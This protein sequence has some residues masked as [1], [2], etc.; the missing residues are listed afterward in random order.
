MKLIPSE[1]W[2]KQRK[3]RKYITN[4]FIIH[5]I[6][7]SAVLKDKYWEDALNAISRIPPSGRLLKVVY[8]RIG[9][10]KVK[11]VTAYWLD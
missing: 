3:F 7:N 4:D 2:K 6:Q 11:I 9:K 8:K 10:N 5:A 1:H